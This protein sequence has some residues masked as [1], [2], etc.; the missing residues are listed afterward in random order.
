MHILSV[1]DTLTFQCSHKGQVLLNL[2]PVIYITDRDLNHIRASGISCKIIISARP[3]QFIRVTLHEMWSHDAGSSHR[4]LRTRKRRRPSLKED[5]L[6]HLIGHEKVGHRQQPIRLR[7][8]RQRHL[9]TSG[10]NSTTSTITKSLTS[11]TSTTSAVG[12]ATRRRATHNTVKRKMKRSDYIA[13]PPLNQVK[14]Q[15][16]ISIALIAEVTNPDQKHPVC[17][18]ASRLPRATVVYTSSGSSLQLIPSLDDLELTTGTDNIMG[19]EILKE[20]IGQDDVDDHGDGDD[21]DDD[22]DDDDDDDGDQVKRYGDFLMSFQG[23]LSLKNEVTN[24]F[25][26]LFIINNIVIIVYYK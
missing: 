24:N 6:E 11:S 16:C 22:G 19:E 3:G 4:W 15:Q 25:F 13:S 26:I 5:N 10:N 17:R 18:G 20:A 8:G 12:V 14:V 9:I 23:E 1:L 7:A 2:E 21:D